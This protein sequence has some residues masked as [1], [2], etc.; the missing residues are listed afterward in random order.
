MRFDYQARTPR[1]EIQS[2]TVEASSREAAVDILQRHKLIVTNLYSVG[3]GSGFASKINLPAFFNKISLRDVSVFSRQL[4]VLFTS[5]VPLVES[6]RTLSDQTENTGFK[7]KIIKISDDVDSGTSFS[8]SIAKYPEVFSTFYVSMVRA[9]EVSGKLSESLLYLSEHYEREYDLNS[10][11]KGAMYY[12]AFVL[13]ALLA[14]MTIMLVF[15]IPSLTSILKESG[16]KLPIITQGIIAMVDFIRTKG[17]IIVILFAAG[18]VFILR[19]KATPKGKKI[20]DKYILKAPIFGKI[21][22]EICLNRFAENLSTLINGG[23][24]ISKAMEVSAD[25]V[26]NETY[27]EVILEAE[28][29]IRRGEFM[30]AIFKMRKDIIPPLV[31]QMILIGEKTGRLPGVLENL[32]KFYQKEVARMTENLVSLVEPLL[33]LILGFGVGFIVVGVLMPIYQMAGSI[34]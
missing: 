11:V 25:V 34:F 23:L 20:W 9:G 1:G 8:K 31:T 2:G 27:K 5:E 26:G 29:G 21:L 15:V 10:K 28:A 30:S 33:I 3:E 7:E 32:A 14:T 22:R 13:V 6:L 16:Q 12:P 4:A 18:I 19:W 17:W 24:P